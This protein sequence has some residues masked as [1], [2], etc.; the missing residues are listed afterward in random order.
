MNQIRVIK[1]LGIFFVFF[2]VSIRMGFWKKLYWQSKGGIYG[3]IPLGLLFIW[4]SYFDFLTSVLS[5][6]LSV[7]YIVFAGLILV[8]IY[9]SIRV[10]QWMKPDWILWI[11]KHPANIKKAMGEE[12][13][14][15][16]SW[17]S[18]VESEESVAIWARKLKK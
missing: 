16:E 13:K 4:Y 17:E 14:T 2:G 8:A 18:N 1:F 11:E 9:L 10:P 7:Y 12:A 5:N 15:N 6:Y 3:Y